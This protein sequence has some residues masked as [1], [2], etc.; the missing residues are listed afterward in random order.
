MKQF[1]Y[2]IFAF[3]F[4]IAGLSVTAG[5]QM[6][7]GRISENGMLDEPF[8]LVPI[9]LVCF[10]IATILMIVGLIKKQNSK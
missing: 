8:F 5:Y 7:G 9:S 4:L 3:L 6:L 2:F 1:K 10:V